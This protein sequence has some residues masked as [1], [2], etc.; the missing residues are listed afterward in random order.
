MKCDDDTFISVPNLLHV[1]LGGT[2]P[3]YNATV[4]FYDQHT[5]NAKNKKNR[6]AQQKQ[7]LMGF[8]FCEVRPIADM[9][10]KW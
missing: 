10:S 8:L 9:T 5:V 6:L 4:S 7:L 1:L 2:L 3:V